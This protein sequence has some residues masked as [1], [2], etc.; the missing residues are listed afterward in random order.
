MSI[1]IATWQDTIPN[2]AAKRVWDGLTQAQVAALLHVSPSLVARYEG[3]N[4]VPPAD[5]WIRWHN[6]LGFDLGVFRHQTTGL[7]NGR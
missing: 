7:Q 6:V 3:L 5:T 2:L 1:I 4:R